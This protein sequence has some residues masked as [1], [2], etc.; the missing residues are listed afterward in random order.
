VTE[1]HSTATAPRP[2]PRPPQPPRSLRSLVH[3]QTV[4]LV[5]TLLRGLRLP[6][7]D[8]LRSCRPRA[9][10][11]RFHRSLIAALRAAHCSRAPGFKN[12]N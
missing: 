1:P 2:Q 12:W 9:R 4:L 11:S 10:C 3:R 6:S 5:A 7:L 8:S